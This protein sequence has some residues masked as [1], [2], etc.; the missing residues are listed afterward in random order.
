MMLRNALVGA[1]V[2]SLAACATAKQDLTVAGGPVAVGHTANQVEAAIE[3]GLKGH[4]WVETGKQPGR[5]TATVS[6]GGK[7]HASATVAIVYSATGYSIEYVDSTGL[8]Y[9][10]KSGAIHK[11]Y[12]RWVA[13]LKADIDSHMN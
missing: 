13:N 2:L 3:A 1:I 9:N 4:N 7:A 6:G 8:S 12:K 10:D 11:T 5:I